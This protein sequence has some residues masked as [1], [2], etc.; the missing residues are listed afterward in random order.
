MPEEVKAY[1]CKDGSITEDYETAV[2]L[3]A[4]LDF[5]EAMRGFLDRDMVVQVLRYRRVIENALAEYNLKLSAAT[6]GP[7]R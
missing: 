1:K 2:G 3:D 5:Q 6:R 7:R 4:Y